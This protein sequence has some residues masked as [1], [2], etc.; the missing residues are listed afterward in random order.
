MRTTRRATAKL[1]IGWRAH[2]QSELR[3]PGSNTML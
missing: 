1:S 3:D 2:A